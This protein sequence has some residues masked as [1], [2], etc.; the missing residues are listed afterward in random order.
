M[1]TV[2][3]LMSE[4]IEGAESGTALD[5][6]IRIEVDKLFYFDTCLAEA[7]GG[8]WYLNMSD[9]NAT[10]KG[11]QTKLK[12]LLDTYRAFPVLLYG[13]PKGAKELRKRA[14]KG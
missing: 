5:G 7:A 14:L 6:N 13:V 11:F 10:T 8:E 3:F 4:F 1:K 9:Y 2:E 12:R